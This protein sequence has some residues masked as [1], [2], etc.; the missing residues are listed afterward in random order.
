MHGSEPL[1]SSPGKFG[2]NWIHASLGSEKFAKVTAEVRGSQQICHAL[3]G[4]NTF[5]NDL[6]AGKHSENCRAYGDDWRT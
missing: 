3:R 1:A 6:H 5:L 4:R 2:K